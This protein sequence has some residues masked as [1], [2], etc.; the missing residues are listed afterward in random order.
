MHELD[1]GAGQVNVARQQVHTID[2][3]LDDDVVRGEAA[4]HQE[5]VDGRVQLMRLDAEA[6]RQGA[7]RI[8]VHQ[9]YAA[10]MLCQRRAEV[11]SRRGLADAALLVADGGN[12]GWPVHQQRLGYREYRHRPP[13]RSNQTGPDLESLGC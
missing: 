2:T 13:R 3:G 10:A 11:D 9:Q 5:V 1:L 8:E 12:P 7:L 4:L 6:H